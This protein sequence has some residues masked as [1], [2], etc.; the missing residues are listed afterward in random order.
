LQ[1]RHR[2]PARTI[3]RSS[4]WSRKEAFMSK[5]PVVL[6]A[7]AMIA[8]CTAFAETTRT[9]RATLTGDAAR[10]FA[11]ENLAGTMTV[12][13]GDGTTVEAVATVHAEDSALADA[14]AFAQ[15]RA[16]SGLPTLRLSY[17][18]D[19]HRTFRYPGSGSS[20]VEYAGR[21]VKVS[22]RTGVLLWADVEVRV[23][24]Q[25]LE[26]EFYNL[27]G[28]LTAD[29]VQGS[30]RLDGASA[31]IAVRRLAGTV[32]ADTGSGDVRA[33]SLAGSFTCDTG[34]GD[35]TIAG[36]DGD[37]ISCDTGSG[38][39]SARDVKATR[40]RADTGSGHVRVENADV[41]TFVGDTGSGDVLLQAVG[42]RLRRAAA[43]T[44][45][46]DFTVYLPPDAA[47][48]LDADVGSGDIVSRFADAQAI[49][50]DREVVGYRRGA[51]TI[52]IDAD[53]GSGDVLVAPR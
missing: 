10:S 26:A 30:V 6:A 43:D 18:V 46:G 20:N 15:V 36:F 3:S 24:R 1:R 13:A 50:H 19:D 9:V 40:V 27:V 34:S 21:K 12:V 23:P 28:T 14:V 35:C 41:E 11:V 22:S 44:G 51:G 8:T 2:E 25:I 31:D 33:E 29:G 39:I 7:V 48:E 42:T 47:F 5:K 53:L 37:D 52:R 49:V 32:V 16:H 4:Q 17:P 38:D 45:S